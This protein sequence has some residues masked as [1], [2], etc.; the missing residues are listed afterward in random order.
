MGVATST[1]YVRDDISIDYYR[2]DRNYEFAEEQ[3][4]E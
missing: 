1:I 3:F 2:T 4:K